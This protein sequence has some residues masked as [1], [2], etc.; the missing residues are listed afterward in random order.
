MRREFTIT[1]TVL[2][3]AILGIVNAMI[4]KQLYMRGIIIDE[5]ITGTITISDLMFFVFFIW[6]LIGIL[7]GALRR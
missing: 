6:V 3:C 1:L 4:I 5:M 7:L 2:V